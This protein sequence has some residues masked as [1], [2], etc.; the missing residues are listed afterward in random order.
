MKIKLLPSLKV[1]YER[2]LYNSVIAS[3]DS[4]TPAPKN[5]PKTPKNCMETSPCDFVYL[6]ISYK[7]LRFIFSFPSGASPSGTTN[8]PFVKGNLPLLW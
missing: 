1:A 6:N 4:F 7:L 8:K 2:F 5:I 3:L